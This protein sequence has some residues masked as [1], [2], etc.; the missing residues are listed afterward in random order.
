M[1]DPLDVETEF[2][3]AADTDVADS[4]WFQDTHKSPAEEIEKTKDGFKSKKLGLGIS[5]DV[6]KVPPK[7]TESF[8]SSKKAFKK[9]RSLSL[10]R[11]AKKRKKTANREDDWF[12]GSSLSSL[13]EFGSADDADSNTDSELSDLSDWSDSKEFEAGTTRLKSTKYE[14][15]NRIKNKKSKKKDVKSFPK[16][17]KSVTQDLDKSAPEKDS[18]DKAHSESNF[19]IRRRPGRRR[20]VYLDQPNRKDEQGRPQILYFAARG[21]FDSCKKLVEHGARIDAKDARGWTLLHEAARQGN[22]DLGTYLMEVSDSTNRATRYLNANIQASN[23]NT[24]LHEAV[25]YNNP[26]FIEFLLLNGARAD[27]KNNLGHTPTDL[28]NNQNSLAILESSLIDLRN[29]LV[30]DKAGQTRLHRACVSGDFVKA[31]SQLNLGIE[32]NL[33]DN[34]GWTPLH[35]ASLSGHTLIVK[36]L[37][38]R[39]ANTT[40]KGLGDDTPLHDACANGHLEVVKLLLKSKADV[41]AKNL[42]GLTP[43]EIAANETIRNLVIEF[44]ASDLS[45]NSENYESSNEP[46]TPSNGKKLIKE[47][48]SVKLKKH[49]RHR[50]KIINESDYSEPEDIKSSDHLEEFSSKNLKLYKKKS[51]KYELSPGRAKVEAESQTSQLKKK[52]KVKSINDSQSSSDSEFIRGR[53]RKEDISIG[54]SAEKY[55]PNS[56]P[57]KR[58]KLNDSDDNISFYYPSN[59]PRISREERKLKSILSTL[60]KIE[61]RQCSQRVH[62]VPS[63]VSRKGKKSKSFDKSSKDPAHKSRESRYSKS[64]ENP[65]DSTSPKNVPSKLSS[66]PTSTPVIGVIKRG[67]GRPPKDKTLLHSNITSNSEAKKST[68]NSKKSGVIDENKKSQSD[69]IKN[70]PDLDNNTFNKNKEDETELKMVSETVSEKQTSGVISRYKGKGV[71]VG[72]GEVYEVESIVSY[73]EEPSNINKDI[74]NADK[75]NFITRIDSKKSIVDGDRNF[76]ATNSKTADEVQDKGDTVVDSVGKPSKNDFK[77][78]NID[79]KKV[80]TNTVDLQNSGLG[81]DEIPI[82]TEAGNKS[83]IKVKRPILYVFSHTKSGEDS[84]ENY[85]TDIQIYLYLL[86]VYYSVSRQ[87]PTEVFGDLLKDLAKFSVFLDKELGILLTRSQKGVLQKV[88]EQSYKTVSSVCKESVSLEYF[89]SLSDGLKLSKVPVK[90]VPYRHIS[91]ILK[92]IFGSR[93][94]KLF[95]SDVVKLDFTE[96]EKLKTLPE[97]GSGVEF[98]KAS[99]NFINKMYDIIHGS[100]NGKDNIIRGDVGLISRNEEP[101]SAAKSGESNSYTICSSKNDEIPFLSKSTNVDTLSKNGRVSSNKENNF[102]DLGLSL[103]ED[104]LENYSLSSQANRSTYGSLIFNDGIFCSESRE[105]GFRIGANKPKCFRTIPRKYSAKL[106]YSNNKLF[107]F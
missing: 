84:S 102:S 65:F 67:R 3:S 88:F 82:E 75:N 105:Y 31:L 92:E 22:I 55:T 29:A 54:F 71:G 64:E 12:S 91:S 104:V 69:S 53:V 41:N 48:P 96:F 47:E 17:D 60:A 38:R 9:K 106:E 5:N 83:E 68:Q 66:T 89:E 51:K 23:G 90:F 99:D 24:P 74:T 87:K 10:D 52:R 81:L 59:T 40:G 6:Y 57:S 77:E 61:Q 35:E 1:S 72:V 27:I 34:A 14:I 30:C 28:C 36:E 80:D 11:L 15:E 37:L 4:D 58:N 39:G 63:S 21:D 49:K 93:F 98:F 18:V 13:N 33:A 16:T 44:K 100:Y 70:S 73:N 42:N 56:S 94:M 25:K 85:V 8:S 46:I 95:F 45:T 101:I 107:T 26:D 19:R 43:A 20:K 76:T 2:F 79:I 103:K 7:A 62:S 32:V 78:T 86:C 97:K 50:P